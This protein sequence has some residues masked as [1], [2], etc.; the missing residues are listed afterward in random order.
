MNKIYNNATISLMRKKK[1]FEMANT[2]IPQKG[3][4]FR[5]RKIRKDKGYVR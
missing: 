4:P 1:L 5:P 3:S 2:W